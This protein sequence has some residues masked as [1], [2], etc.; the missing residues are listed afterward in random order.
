MHH[1]ISEKAAA[2]LHNCRTF[3][4]VN[5]GRKRFFGIVMF[6][7]WLSDRRGN[8]AVL[9]AL[10]LP[11]L[12]GFAGLGVEVGYWQF[13]QRQ[14]QSAADLAAY[15]GAVS[16]R[17][18]EPAAQAREEAEAEARLHGYDAAAGTF[19]ANT[20][21]L[22]GSFRNARSMEVEITQSLPRFFSAIFANEPLTVSVRAVATYEDEADACLLAL[23]PDAGAAIDFFGTSTVSLI[24]C[25][26]MSNS[27][28][29]NAVLL[30]GGTEVQAPCINSVGG[31]ALGGGSASYNLTACAAPR[32]NLPRARDPY[33]HVAPPD[34]PAGCSN[35][36]GGGPNRGTVTIDSGASGVKR[37][38]NGLNL[39]GDY[40]FEPGVYVIDGGDFRIGA[41][42]SIAG[43]GVTFYLTD[44]ARARFNGSAEID[45]L[46]PSTGD[47]AGLAI[48][49]DRNDFGVEHTFDGSAG[50]SIT[51]AIYTPA[52]NINFHGSFSGQ[53]GCMQLVGYTVEIGGA[54]SIST[55][56]TGYGLQYSRVPSDVRLVE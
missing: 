30:R 40:V 32:T 55:D 47:Y 28:A 54:A 26:V 46:A 8:T 17:N 37:F 38:C 25:E 24:N 11:L 31:F 36:R 29:D 14:S 10:C 9:F 18:R 49:G 41:N 6:A 56:C 50:S 7:L 15:A 22:A 20:A 1:K 21:P 27:I 42:A 4:C 52:S 43:D 48:F 34:I 16:L 44:G 12:L 53:D 2:P 19:V 39:I 45:L 13:R 5:R 35:I 33:A 23:S 3:S 51:G